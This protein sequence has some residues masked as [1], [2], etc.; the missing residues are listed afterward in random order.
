M[1]L[2]ALKML[3][4]DRS[5]YIMLVGGLSF[6]SLL[7]TQQNGVFQGLLSWTTSHMRNMRASIWVVESRVEQVNETKALRD[8]DVNRVR[9]VDGVDFAEPLFQGVIKARAFDGSDKQ[10]QLIG[11]HGGT[12]FG[13]PTRMIDGDI[14]QLRVANSVVVDELA[15]D[16][17][18]LGA[19]LGRRLRVGDTFEINDREAR[20]VGICRTERHFFGYPYV[21][22]TYDQALQYAPR[23]RKMLSMILAEPRPG[24]TAEEAARRITAET[25]LR[26]YTVPEFERST[27]GWVWRNTGIPASFMTTIILGFLVGVAVCG[28]TYYYFV[29]ENLK[30]LG[31]LKAMGASNGLLSG[32][33]LFQALTVGVIGYGIGL[34]LT[35]LFGLAVA[36]TGQP[37][38]RLVP[39]YLWDSFGAVLLIC[40]LAALFGIRKVAR[41]EPAIVFRG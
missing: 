25:G 29:L 16:P 18:R 11:L 17:T 38:F 27:I 22:T 31:A 4:G 30:N 15:A 26:A 39:M 8:T 40:V 36:K 1:Y 20:V 10:V 19:G 32:M 37:P 3:L 6:S 34:G 41:L 35:A 28:Q 23:Q 14:A 12:L 2:L 7:M 33:L 13:R 9:S 24:V 5:K 21:F